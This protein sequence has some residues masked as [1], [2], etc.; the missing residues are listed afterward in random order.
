MS[1]PAR[2]QWFRSGPAPGTH[3]RLICFPFAGGGAS[4]FHPWQSLVP[5]D[6][7]VCPV[8]LPGR[9]SRYNEPP[10]RDLRGLVQEL[11]RAVDCFV[12]CPYALFGH[13]LGG[14]LAFEL[15]R[16]LRSLGKPAPVR[17][18]ASACRAPQL[19]SRREPIHGLEDERF[20]EQLTRLTGL[21]TNQKADFEIVR[22]LVPVLKADFEMS[23]T[24]RYVAEPAFTF[25]ITALG[26]NQDGLVAAGDL[27]AWHLQTAGSF[28]L[29]LLPGGHLFLRSSPGRVLKMI[30]EEVGRSYDGLASAECSV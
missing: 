7:Q 11:V 23:D 4:L 20:L 15:A 18:F 27:V 24:Y 21:S 22:L 25:P 28:R 3:L 16:E 6:V 13:S 30:L 26:G 17:F 19:P 29:R 14:L 9:D 2:G 1:M 5:R 8:E 12:D 10:R